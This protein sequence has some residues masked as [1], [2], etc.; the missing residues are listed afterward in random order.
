MTPH[1]NP[2]THQT[3]SLKK[4][5]IFNELAH[6]TLYNGNSVIKNEKPGVIKVHFK[7]T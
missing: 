5:K 4:G 3:D 2:Q 6:G 1:L 7:E